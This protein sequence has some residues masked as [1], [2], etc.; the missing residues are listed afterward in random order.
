MTLS[1]AEAPQAPAAVDG[2]L[3]AHMP[4]VVAALERAGHPTG[5]YV[6][7]VDDLDP[8]QGASS[9]IGPPRFSTAYFALRN[10]PSVLVECH[11]YKPYEERV[12]AN[13]DFLLA[14]LAEVGRD[15]AGLVR[16]VEEAE[17]RT[18]AL[19]R[20]E[21]PASEVTVRL[22]ESQAPD[23]LRIPIYEWEVEPSIV[24]GA[25]LLRYRTGRV[26]PIEVPWL[27]RA[28]VEKALPRPRGYLVLPGWPAIEERLRGHGL[29]VE[30][31]AAPAELEVE[32]ARLSAPGYAD[33]SY[34]GLT[35]VE[36]VTVERSV[37]RRSFPAGTL[38]VPAD[39]PDFEVAVQLLE[40]EAP[41]SLLSWGLIS[42]VFESKEYI[43]PRVLDAWAQE[44]LQSPDVAAEWQAALADEAFAKD[45]RAR[46]TWWYRRHPAWD[47]TRGLHPVFRVLAPPRL[48][49]DPW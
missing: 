27:H 4:A 12:L 16:A 1:W 23:T 11:S 29:R 47:Q 21:A 13:R 19:G 30:R 20:P 28:E 3:R 24:T 10:R 15:P 33:S 35:R 32:A 45:P 43:E 18:V 9:W 14:L 46:F 39:Q 8:A 17:R 36:S 44:Q 2:W 7:L 34:Q 31:L 37:E 22:R 41:D 5:P 49:T 40:P 38:W 6:D 26:R 25:P 48:A 42:N